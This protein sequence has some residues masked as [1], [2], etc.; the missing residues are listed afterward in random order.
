LTKP[1]LNFF[2]GFQR[3]RTPQ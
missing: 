3:L 2:G 1:N